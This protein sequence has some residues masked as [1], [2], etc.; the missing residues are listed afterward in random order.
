M[1]IE[2]TEP[3]AFATHVVGR[4]VTHGLQTVRGGSPHFSRKHLRLVVGCADDHE[5]TE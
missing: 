3:L 2:G 1:S 4:L 5:E